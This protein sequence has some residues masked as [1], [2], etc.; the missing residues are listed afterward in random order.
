MQNIIIGGSVRSGK[1]T[2]GNIIARELNL[3]PLE[4]L[5]DKNGSNIL[6]SQTKEGK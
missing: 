4:V 3:D 2:L 1:T 6:K 5:K